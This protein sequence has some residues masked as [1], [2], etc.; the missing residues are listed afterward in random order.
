VKLVLSTNESDDFLK[1]QQ[2]GGG[3]RDVN[4]E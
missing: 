1:M 4:D 2:D 3:L